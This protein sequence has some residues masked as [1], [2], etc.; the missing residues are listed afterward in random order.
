MTG[1]PA[2]HPPEFDYRPLF[3]PRSHMP[4]AY[5]G[6]AAGA[7]HELRDQASLLSHP[8]PRRLALKSSLH[9]PFGRLFVHIFN[10]HS[11]TPVH[12][13]LDASA[14]MGCEGMERKWSL[15]MDFIDSLAYSAWRAGD[16]FGLV[17][18]NDAL[19]LSIPATRSE[20]MVRE[21]LADLRRTQPAGGV[22][23]LDAAI[24]EIAPSQ[25]M[26]F[27]VTDGHLGQME[28]DKLMEGLG[29]HDLVPVLIRDGA[30]SQPT[31]RSGLARLRD[32]ETGRERL[33]W[34]RPGLQRSMA[35]QARQRTLELARYFRGHGLEPLFLDDGIKPT[36]LNAYFAER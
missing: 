25:A 8:D 20:A 29:G 13:L 21:Q 36:L 6:L 24:Q 35:E 9:D 17:A 16:P 33:L 10:Q 30:E 34:L 7:G 4:G 22:G 3:R 19:H 14:S 12:V 1:G 28:L 18:W 15:A 32:A 27:L 23:A 11:R 2:G 31:R 26:V 5:K